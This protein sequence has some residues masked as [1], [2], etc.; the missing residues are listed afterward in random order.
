MEITLNGTKGAVVR[1]GAK[2]T[3]EQG[4]DYEPGVSAETVGSQHVFMGIVTL[5][6]GRRT[7]AHVHQFHETA[8]YMIG[9]E[10]IDLYTGEQ[11]E[12]HELVAAGDYLYVPAN[13]LHVAVNR[14]TVPAVFVA[15]R[16]E[17]TLNE[18][19]ILSPE[20]DRLVP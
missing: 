10:P 7:K 14:G 4:S 13:V 12:H 16:N 5:P 11:L 18:R 3:A 9:G 19:L 2:F 17:A 15:T 1:A 8:L 6:P 20:K